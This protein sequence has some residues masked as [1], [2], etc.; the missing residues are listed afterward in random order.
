MLNCAEVRTSTHWQLC[1]RCVSFVLPVAQVNMVIIRL[2]R[3]K[4]LMDAFFVGL[5]PKFVFF[6]ETERALNPF[7]KNGQRDTY[8][9]GPKVLRLR[10]RLVCKWP[11]RGWEVA[12][13]SPKQKLR[14]MGRDLVRRKNQANL[15]RNWVFL[16]I[17]DLARRKGSWWNI[18]LRE[19]RG[20]PGGTSPDLGISVELPSDKKLDWGFLGDPAA[21]RLNR[22]ELI[23]KCLLRPQLGL[24]QVPCL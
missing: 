15:L 14:G 17:S 13:S 12:C 24:R 23:L 19:R 18:F 9:I 10:W 1:R 20:L 2:D 6:R 22:R 4:Q 7:K 5:V 21:L 8:S 3:L 16:L 11:R